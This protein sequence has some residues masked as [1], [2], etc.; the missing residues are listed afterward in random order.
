MTM[1][2]TQEYLPI[3]ILEKIIMQLDIT[4]LKTAR[5][6]CDYWKEV[7]EKWLEKS[8]YNSSI[9]FRSYSIHICF[10]SKKSCI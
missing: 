6:V 8:K 1:W 9:D 4:S 7:A 5:Q 3:E 2:S 10:V